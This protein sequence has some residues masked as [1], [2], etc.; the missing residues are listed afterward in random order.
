MST[1]TKKDLKWAVLIIGFVAVIVFAASV[2]TARA[3]AFC[4][5]PFGEYI[6]GIYFPSARPGWDRGG[7]GPCMPADYANIYG[8]QVHRWFEQY[9][10]LGWFPMSGVPHGG[11]WGRPV[12]GGY[13]PVLDA[14]ERP[15]SGRQ[16]F[17]RAAGIV[18]LGTGI[19]AAKGGGKGAA[20]GALISGGIAAIN[21]SRYR[22]RGQTHVPPPAVQIPA[23]SQPYP[24]GYEPTMVRPGPQG[25]REVVEVRNPFR[26]DVE[27]WHSSDPG[28]TW[29]I[30]KNS[31]RQLPWPP[32]GE[33]FE[34]H[35]RKP[36]DGGG[37]ALVQVQ[38]NGDGPRFI[39]DP[40]E[41]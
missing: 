10:M 8:R 24:P 41:D 19:G 17:E 21:D 33:S 38:V 15:L 34:G 2:S 35:F 11:V 20:I 39:L 26:Y 7:Y 25:Q 36:Q 6:G 27:I 5:D 30:R 23:A 31:S 4:Q 37:W 14:Y 18:A 16:R 29:V 1:T 32:S 3:Q 9:G 28:T 22:G 12:H 13:Q 40:P